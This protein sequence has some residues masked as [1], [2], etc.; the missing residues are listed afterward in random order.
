MNF[1]LGKKLVI[2]NATKELKD[3]CDKTLVFDNPE[4]KKREAMGK[5]TGNVQRKIVL[6]ERDGNYL[7]LPFGVAKDI[8]RKF[9]SGFVKA[10]PFF[11][12]L[13]RRDYQSHI[14]TYDYQER[15]V[16]ACLSAKNGILVAP[17]GSGKT[18]MGLE[19]IARIGGKA[20]WVTHTV[21]LLNQS[22][23]RAKSVYGLDSKEYG[24]VT[25]GKVDI[26]NT[27]TFATVQTLSNIDL[28]QYETEWDIVVVDEC[29]KCVGS[30]TNLMMF[31]K[32][33]SRLYARYKYGLTATEYRADGL[34]RSMF[35]LLGDVIH[36]IPKEEV[37]KNTCPV[38]VRFYDT[39]YVPNYD[40]IL[41]G[42][43]TI[44]YANLIEDISS[45][46]ERNRC[47]VEKIN[48]LDGATI[49][50]CDRLEHLERLRN[51][52]SCD[53]YE[54]S[55]LITGK[56]QSKSAKE[57]RKKVLS[58]LNNGEVQFVFATYKLAKEGLDVPN[59]KYIVLASPQKDKTTVVQSCGRVERKGKDKEFGTVIDFTDD[60]GMLK[61]YERKRKKYYKELGYE[62]L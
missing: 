11:Y 42:D 57:E 49:V 58:Q 2:E 30:P 56:S 39:H 7:L 13:R 51:G 23:E 14:N 54:K 18:Q 12:P 36:K 37:K 19:L 45:N 31:Y 41:A 21:D 33:V 43:G 6:Y 29:H 22:M 24:T 26:G 27:I 4:F 17:C 25:A 32:V 34:E 20:L 38:K 5:W 3:Y 62:I 9:K 40:K 55:R 50:L 52:L 48:K 8:Y 46:E 60:F 53:N 28:C 35:A 1:Y 15:A 10:E 61:G 47:V 44:I 16:Q 59:L